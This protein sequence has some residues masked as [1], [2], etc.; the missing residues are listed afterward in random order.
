ME[1]ISTVLGLISFQLT[2][3]EVCKFNSKL[4]K[5]INTFT[6]GR[7]HGLPTYLAVRRKCGLNA[8]F[9]TFDDLLA[10]FPQTNV[11]LLKNTYASVEDIDLIIGGTLEAFTNLKAIL[12]D[13]F[14]CIV[15]RQYRNIMGAD[16][17]FYSHST[18]PYPFTAAQLSAIK[19]FFQ[20]H[21]ICQNT[22]LTSIRGIYNA[23]PFP[24]NPIVPCTNYPF[25]DLSAWKE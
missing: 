22:N 25:I 17:Y 18:N 13:T 14:S 12:G 23:A 24:Q 20:P 3:K 21:L 2:F 10:I 16:A 9:T 5:I 4:K 15:S 19:A 7:D 1:R 6:K 8:N 11:D